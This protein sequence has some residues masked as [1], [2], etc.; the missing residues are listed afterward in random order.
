MNKPLN[1]DEIDLIDVAQT[2]WDGK[3]IVAVVTAVFALGGFGASLFTSS[4]NFI[5]KTE[6]KPISLSEE[7]K[8]RV[9]NSLGIYRIYVN[10]Q[11]RFAN[12]PIIN[13][14]AEVAPNNF[15]PRLA[16][17]EPSNN[18]SIETGF[19]TT[20]IGS[21]ANTV[22]FI[23]LQDSFIQLLDRGVAFRAAF[24]KFG[25]LN[26]AN[27]DSDADYEIAIAR[28]VASIDILPPINLDGESTGEIRRNHTLVF[29]HDDQEQ[30]H[31]IL[32]DVAVA[33]NTEMQ[34]AIEYNFESL[35]AAENFKRQTQIEDLKIHREILVSS[36]EQ[37]TAFKIELLKEHAA[38]A[39][40]LGIKDHTPAALT[41]KSKID[42]ALTDD[43][44]LS[45][46]V[47]SGEPLYLRGYLSLEKEIDIL[48]TQKNIE[49]FINGLAEIDRQIVFIERDRKIERLKELFRLTPAATSDQFIAANLDVEAS[50]TLFQKSRL[51][52]MLVF[53]TIT[54]LLG[55]A[56]YLIIADALRQRRKLQAD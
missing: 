20:G 13:N 12:L 55:S 32:K 14:F 24:K 56:S 40:Q 15:T 49:L 27:Y 23:S 33:I 42:S 39:R 9:F 36:F 47:N 17:K 22:P 44:R 45:S 5:S 37:K 50:K 3:F 4:P 28:L 29:R 46:G 26:R 7:N 2:I 38:I 30:W 19:N 52:L 18:H 43:K 8:Y 35:M 48:R 16:R 41:F 54:G 11:A 10:E 31:S 1:N 34:S 25:V 21:G 53:S 6:I 51:G